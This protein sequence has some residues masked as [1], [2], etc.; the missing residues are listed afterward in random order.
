MPRPV[1]Y[2]AKNIVEVTMKNALHLIQALLLLALV[3]LSIFMAHLLLIPADIEP[4][5]PKEPEVISVPSSTV[6]NGQAII[7]PAENV[8]RKTWEDGTIGFRTYHRIK[9]SHYKNGKMTDSSQIYAYPSYPGLVPERIVAEDKYRDQGS[10]AAKYHGTNHFLFI[11]NRE[12]PVEVD[13]DGILIEVWWSV[14][15]SKQPDIQDG[16]LAHTYFDVDK[17]IL[18]VLMLPPGGWSEPRLKIMRHEI[19]SK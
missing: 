12:G 13:E 4:E 8:I 2:I 7:L 3:L 10:S 6:F 5:E 14:D 1:L 17:D 18:V 16:N 9:P 11:Y 19:L 15:F